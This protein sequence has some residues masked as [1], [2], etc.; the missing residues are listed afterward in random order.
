MSVIFR[1]TWSFGIFLSMNAFR[2]GSTNFLTSFFDGEA[3]S[4]SLSGAYRQFWSVNFL[5]FLEP[6]LLCSESSFGISHTGISAKFLKAY[7]LALANL[8]SC[9]LC[10]SASSF[11]L[12]SFLALRSANIFSCYSFIFLARSFRFLASSSSCYSFSSSKT[13][14]SAALM[15]TWL[16]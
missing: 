3:F 1:N 6:V 9:F 7:S 12:A 14:A 11:S 8:F 16:T 5:V 13:A 10:F 2:L 4:P 15:T